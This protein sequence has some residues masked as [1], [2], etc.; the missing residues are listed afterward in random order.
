V[1]AWTKDDWREFQRSDWLRDRREAYAD[2]K[3][4]EANDAAWAGN[5]AAER[6]RLWWQNKMLRIRQ[7]RLE[8][9]MS[10]SIPQVLSIM[11]GILFF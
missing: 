10:V 11:F 4:K 2:K 8:K 6:R 3:A 7:Q 5:N 9:D 1:Q